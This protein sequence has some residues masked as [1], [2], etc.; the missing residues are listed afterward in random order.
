MWS[1]EAKNAINHLKV[2]ICK[3]LT[4]AMPNFQMEFRLECDAAGGGIGAVLSQGGWP[5]AYLS[6]SLSPKHLS[7]PIYEKE[8]MAVVYAV[9]KWHP[10]LIGR[11]FKIYTDHF[12]LKYMLNQCIST[13]MQQKWLSKLIGNDF[14]I[15]H[16]SGKEDKAANAL[17]RMNE[18]VE[19]AIMMA[20]SFPFAEWVEQLKQE[21]QQNVEI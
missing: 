15:H 3:A 17:S 19:K 2:A 8:M 18:S 4:L 20:I 11:H 16:R 10:Y 14:E 7:M 21:W 5:I 13:P 9:Q 6:K 12:S 1:K